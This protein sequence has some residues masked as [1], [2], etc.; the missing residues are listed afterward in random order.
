[1]KSTWKD[2]PQTLE[3]LA[4]E[5]ALGTLQG[6]ARR[7]FEAVMGQ[8]REVAAAVHAW[9]DRLGR[10]LAAQA[11]LPMPTDAWP[12]LEA[13]LFGKPSPVAATARMRWYQRWLGAMPAGALAVGLFLGVM[14][15][16]L[17]DATRRNSQLPESYVGVLA[18]AAGAP[19]LIV[20]SLRHGRTVDLKALRAIDVPAGKTL[21]LWTLDR[22]GVPKPVAPLPQG[23]FVSVKLPQPAEDVF[24]TAVELAVSVEPV[25]VQPPAPSGPYV[26]RGL[27]GKLWRLPGT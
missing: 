15:A 10:L 12:K 6:P 8:R 19:G 22:T 21:F 9:H 18:D 24:F 4:G 16:P 27:C 2:H 1:M 25:G 14:L 3:R 5:Y 7:R 17:L 13:R 20:S 26:Y 23:Q 11:P